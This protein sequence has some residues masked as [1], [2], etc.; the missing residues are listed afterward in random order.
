MEK[1]QGTKL[2]KGERRKWRVVIGIVLLVLLALAV[3]FAIFL[4]RRETEDE[5]APS[6]SVD[7]Q[8]ETSLSQEMDTEGDWL[9]D[10]DFVMLTENFTERKITDTESA[11]AAMD[12]AADRIGV[13]DVQEE[14]SDDKTDTV[15]G[16]TY[17]RFQQ[18]YEGI[19]VYGRSVVVAADENGT[20]LAMTG[21]Y[22][23]LGDLDVQPAV[24]S[25]S[26]LAIAGEIY[27]DGMEAINEGLVIYSLYDQEP[28][29]AWV[30]CVVSGDRK[31]LCFISAVSGEQLAA[32]SLIANSQEVCTGLDVDG[33][34][35]EFYAEYEENTYVLEDTSRDITIYDAN[36]STLQTQLVII[37]SNE[38]IYVWEDE[39]WKDKNG[40]VVTVTGE[41]FSFVIRDEEDNIIGTQGIYT[42]RLT[43]KNPFTTVEPVVSSTADWDNPK[44]VTLLSRLS[45][46]YDFWL[47]QF[48]RHSYDDKFGAVTAVYDDY[49]NGDTTNAQANG[50]QE[51][52]IAVLTF[53]MDHSLSLDAIAHEFMHAVEG[54]IVNF[55]YEGESGALREAYGDIFGEIVEDWE[56][57]GAYDSDCDWTL[58]G[59]NMIS[60]G[61][62]EGI[63]PD[64]YQGEGWKDTE[65]LSFDNGGVHANSTV[66]SHAAYLMTTGIGGNPAFEALS[67]YQ[68]GRL[69]YETLHLLPSDCTFSEFRMLIQNMAE[70]LNQQGILT[71]KQCFCVSNAFF[72]V[73]V[74]ETTLLT[75]RE[76]FLNVYGGN[77][78]LYEDY[79]LHVRH[80][81]TETIYDGTA[82]A[83]E[84]LSFSDTGSYE[85]Y[86]VDNANEDNQESLWIQVAE[87]GGAKQLSVFTKCGLADV[88]ELIPKETAASVEFSHHVEEGMESAVITGKSS[89]GEVIWTHETGTYACAELARVSGLTMTGD[90]YYYIEDGAVVALDLAT[91]SVAWENRE[92]GGAAVSFALGEDGTLYLCGYYGPDFFAV[93]EDGDTIHKIDTLDSQFYWPYAMEYQE[94]QILIRYEG[95]SLEG[96]SNICA[97]LSLDD[98][99]FSFTYDEEL[100]AEKVIQQ[101]FDGDGQ[102]EILY[103]VFGEEAAPS[104]KPV[105]IGPDCEIYYKDE[106]EAIPVRLSQ[107]KR[108]VLNSFRDLFVFQVDSNWYA[109]ANF[110][111][112]IAAEFVATEIYC[113]EGNTWNLA[114]EFEGE[115]VLENGIPYIKEYLNAVINGSNERLS[116][117]IFGEEQITI[118]NSQDNSEVIELSPVLSG[119]LDEIAAFIGVKPVWIKGTMCEGISLDGLEVLSQDSNS[120]E[121]CR[122]SNSNPHYSIYASSSSDAVGTGNTGDVKCSS[123]TNRTHRL[124]CLFYGRANDN[125]PDPRSNRNCSKDY[126]S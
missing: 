65:D 23:P 105:L 20:A 126:S 64:V 86:I 69:F 123:Q 72:Q 40:N 55:V 49:L 59:R 67:T 75:E 120:S 27:G 95:T 110:N 121:K 85:L 81:D 26:A 30:F 46:I 84:G 7:T 96:I 53:G 87:E 52:P 78:E 97:A 11:R 100:I 60:P 83:R 94:G 115:C 3:S 4:K 125:K 47:Y 42:A 118:D 29:L 32:H 19:P 2:Q 91:G 76:V 41:D 114:A 102:Q 58:N 36:Q 119:T 107:P 93:G 18:E 66:I 122:I 99:S 112:K 82:V 51:V 80:G 39:Q 50:W 63:F 108:Y 101:D 116:P 77:G 1:K 70:I 14:F 74:E 61:Q 10:G 88:D 44:A 106:K 109:A 25:E 68:L 12:D 33:E 48:D 15:F 5:A 92:F 103:A 89:A 90:T 21:N 56:Q 9:V 28:E 13:T 73:G 22:L 71:P 124:P 117:L 57:D 16:N 6:Q 43:T 45:Q 35:Q 111:R 38:Q 8:D 98:Y 113:L 31:E 24:D 34:T 17:H 104:E 62:S 37:D 54:N 79:T